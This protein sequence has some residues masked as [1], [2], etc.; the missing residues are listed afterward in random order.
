V[1]QIKCIEQHFSPES[2]LVDRG[3]NTRRIISAEFFFTE[4]QTFGH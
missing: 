4:K 2:Y 1:H 3:V